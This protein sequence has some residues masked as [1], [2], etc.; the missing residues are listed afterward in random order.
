MFVQLDAGKPIPA[1]PVGGA[2]EYDLAVIRL[3]RVPKDLRPIPLGSSRDLKIGQAVYAIGN[4]FGLQRT[5]TKGLV[6][7]LDR[8]L[9]TANFREVVGVIQTD[10]AINPGNSGGP[11]LNI[12]G[13]LIGINTA[14]HRGGPGIGFAIPIDRSRRI[15]D[16]LNQAAPPP[17]T[18]PLRFC[19]V[20]VA[21]EAQVAVST[22]GVRSV[23]SNHILAPDT[24]GSAI[25]VQPPAQVLGAGPAYV[26]STG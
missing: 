20:Q 12:E 19:P 10:A 4:P 22:G 13:Q 15:V 9:P 11:L 7:A 2:P 24:P 14:V 3:S 23:A 17:Q 6:S 5:L 1:E 8:E 26:A 16:D 18:G 21:G 25:C